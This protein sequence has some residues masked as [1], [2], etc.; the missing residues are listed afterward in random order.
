ME[1]ILYSQYCVSGV[2]LILA[3]S[4][5]HISIEF[6]YLVRP[7]VKLGSE[8]QGPLNRRT[9]TVI[10]RAFPTMSPQPQNEPRRAAKLNNLQKFFTIRSIQLRSPLPLEAK[11]N[12]SRRRR[13]LQPFPRPLTSLLHWNLRHRKPE[14]KQ[15][16]DNNP[17]CRHPLGDNHPLQQDLQRGPEP[18][19]PL[20][21]WRMRPVTMRSKEHP[22]EQEPPSL[23]PSL[24]WMMDIT[25]KPM[26]RCQRIS[27]IRCWRR[28]RKKRKW[29]VPWMCLCLLLIS[30]K[31]Y[32][33]E[34]LDTDASD[35][36]ADP[37]NRP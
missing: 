21:H 7:C 5:E 13:N 15:P 23:D 24:S 17:R 33:A 29:C 3:T 37:D 6:A 16:N 30:P 10:A 12:A 11:T 35:A 9:P 36:E 8:C 22:E 20:L 26:R 1:N 2:Q 32:S 14:G 28:R 18:L 31:G 27:V 25:W 19:L 4:Q 34:N